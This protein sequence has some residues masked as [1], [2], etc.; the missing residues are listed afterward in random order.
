MIVDNEGIYSEYIVTDN[1]WLNVELP[2]GQGGKG[3]GSPGG[4]KFTMFDGLP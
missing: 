1:W 4:M 3:Q 2:S